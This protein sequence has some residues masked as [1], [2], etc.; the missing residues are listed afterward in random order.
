MI[1]LSA[2]GKAHRLS[3]PIIGKIA[4]LETGWSHRIQRRQEWDGDSVGD[5]EAIL[6]EQVI[7]PAILSELNTPVVHGVST[8]HLAEGDVVR[9]DGRGHVRTLYRRAS[10]FNALF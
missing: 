1:P 2:H 9:L 3:E 6:C 5:F 7:S 8:A 10:K 4:S